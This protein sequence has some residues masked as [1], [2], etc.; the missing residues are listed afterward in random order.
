VPVTLAAGGWN[1]A[2]QNRM[3]LFAGDV[4][5][6]KGKLLDSASPPWDSFSAFI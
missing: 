6:A 3:P 2:P 5:A 1:E 4:G